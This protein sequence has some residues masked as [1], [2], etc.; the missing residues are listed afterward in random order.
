MSGRDVLRPAKKSGDLIV[1]PGIVF[2]ERAPDTD[3]LQ[4]ED[5]FAAG[6]D[7]AAQEELAGS[8]RCAPQ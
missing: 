8:F 2:A 1:C 3:V 4:D 7:H 6:S 5:G